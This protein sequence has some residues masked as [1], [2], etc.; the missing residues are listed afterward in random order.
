MISRNGYAKIPGNMVNFFLCQLPGIRRIKEGYILR[1]LCIEVIQAC[2]KRG[3]IEGAEQTAEQQ[4]G[5]DTHAAHHLRAQE[6][7][8]VV[9]NDMV[10]V[11]LGPRSLFMAG[12]GVHQNPVNSQ[13]GRQEK[14][15]GQASQATME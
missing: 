1:I 6:F 14:N 4:Q 5:N 7:H 3:D 2:H 15:G 10:I 8:H 11:V 12:N 9:G 13:E